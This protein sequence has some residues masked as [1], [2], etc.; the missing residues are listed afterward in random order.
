MAIE[1]DSMKYSLIEGE[2]ETAVVSVISDDVTLDRDVLVMLMTTN[3]SAGS[4]V[5]QVLCVCTLYG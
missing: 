4:G 3:G 2:S 5:V 1:L